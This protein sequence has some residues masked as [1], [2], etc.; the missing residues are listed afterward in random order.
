MLYRLFTLF[1]LLNIVTLNAQVLINE[2]SSSNDSVIL[3]EDG[4]SSDWIELY[5]AGTAAVNLEGWF[6]SDKRSE[7]QVWTFPN[8]TIGAGEFLLIFASGEDKAETFLHT[9]FKLSK[10][11][12][13]LLL[14]NPMGE[15]MDKIFVL[16]LETDISYGRLSDGGAEWGFFQIPT[17]Q[18]TNNEGTVIGVAKSPEFLVDESF[19][20]N[21]FSLEMTTSEAGGIIRY[22]LDGSE[23]EDDSFV[24][25]NP[26]FIEENTPVRA[27]T[28]KVGKI[29]S[30]RTS[31]TYF[32]N[33]NHSLPIIH[34]STA[35]AN[36]FDYE[37]GILVEGPD[38]SPDYPFFGANFWKDIEAPIHFEYF[39][40]NQ[41]LELS[42][43]MGTQTHGGRGTRT[44]P[45][46]AMRLTTKPKFGIDK[47]NYQFFRNK[48]ANSFER[49]VLRNSGG[50]FSDTH[51]RSGFLAN[52]LIDSGIDVDVLGYQP[53][54]LYLNGQYWGVINLREKSDEF[55]IES[56]YGIEPDQMDFL[57]EDTLVVVGNFDVFDQHFEYITTHDMSVEANFQQAAAYFD[58]NSMTDYFVSQLAIANTDWPQGNIKYWRERKT[59]AK[60]RYMMFDLDAGMGLYPWSNIDREA[61]KRI[62]TQQGEINRHVMIHIELMKNENYY[63]YF[64]NRYA[65]LLNTIF[66]PDEF[67]A[68]VEAA[69]ERIRPEIGEHLQRWSGCSFCST[70]ERRDTL[71]LP[72]ILNFAAQ[73][74]VE[75]RKHLQAFFGFQ[76][77]VNL[78]LNTYP[79]G[80]GTVQI[81]TITPDELPWDGYYFNGVPVTLTVVPN[82]G[83]EFSHWEGIET[84][85]S[86]NTGTTFT[87]NF[88]QND[89]VTAFFNAKYEG[90]QVAAFPNPT[91]GN[92]EI[93]FVLNQIEE[94][95]MRLFSADGKLMQNFQKQKLNGGLQ[96]QNIDLTGFKS[97][98][99][100]L[101]V[102]TGETRDAVRI[103]V[104]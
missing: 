43:E 87:L 57:E 70:M 51:F 12:E 17:P 82:A 19:Q 42:V 15:L 78:T 102:Q 11:G 10:D 66:A 34:I 89:Q 48:E 18:A 36:F 101:Y 30:E 38:A 92:V 76:N 54:V 62:I 90:L 80:A 63:N 23:P 55:Y 88:E 32:I 3:D 14:T 71:H 21:G 25:E 64:I 68:A 73:R 26:I 50:D 39:D 65:D 77:Q 85:L 46:K 22:T 61:Y 49:L 67:I 24:Y 4:E 83:F 99:Y 84:D 53:V 41:S 95:E 44:K 27:R 72:N 6:L 91:A 104:E 86:G 58:L 69:N 40:E 31:K 75:N 9:N 2:A 98:V 56:N 81:N 13:Y 60:W 28:Y 16:D 1:F 7:P 74:A 93:S 100:L 96:R 35:P 33:T 29:P 20:N 5:N 52:Y 45:Q 94:V 47:I 8:Q 79:E 103:M 97:G 59:D 37:N